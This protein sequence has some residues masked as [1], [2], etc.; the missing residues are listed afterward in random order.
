[1]EN[2][3]S[4]EKN[5]V[6][7]YSMML[8]KSGINEENKMNQSIMIGGVKKITPLSKLF[9]LL[10]IKKKDK[11]NALLAGYLAKA[12][13]G[14][15]QE[16]KTDLLNYLFMEIHKNIIDGILHYSYNRSISEI[17]RKI[18]IFEADP[19]DPDKLDEYEGQRKII[20]RKMIEKLNGCNYSE[21]LEN[22]AW[23]FCKIIKSKHH[24]KFLMSNEIMDL[25]FH[26]DRQSVV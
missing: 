14:I 3:F 8:S 1:M 15:M 17:L 22:I 2:F 12:F 16:K 11:I 10:E 6:M 25:F 5:D 18:L 13:N 23:V 4:E 9:T 21:G 20:L 19:D 24:I 7:G 26:I